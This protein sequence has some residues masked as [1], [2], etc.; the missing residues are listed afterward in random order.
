MSWRKWGHTWK[1]SM[2][3]RLSSLARHLCGGE[4]LPVMISGLVRPWSL[5][6]SVRRGKQLSPI[7]GTLNAGTT[8][9]MENC[10]VLAQRSKK[11][12]PAGRRS[13]GL[14]AGG[15]SHEFLLRGDWPPVSSAHA[16]TEVTERRRYPL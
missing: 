2:H 11:L 3:M 4:Q 1:C 12:R 7:S 10:V 13:K 8:V 6:L 5:Q 9:S 16:C 15:G 14:L